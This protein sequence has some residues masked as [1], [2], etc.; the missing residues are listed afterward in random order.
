[1]PTVWNAATRWRNR[2]LLPHL[3][4][5]LLVGPVLPAGLAVDEWQAGF[6]NR[7]EAL[8]S[9]CARKQNA[10]MSGKRRDDSVGDL[11]DG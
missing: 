8:V 10:S 6:D 11:A 4:L 2:I 5:L 1:L 7:G 3:A 9:G